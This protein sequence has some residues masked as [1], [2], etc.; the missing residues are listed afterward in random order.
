LAG[1]AD[2][3]SVELTAEKGQRHCRYAYAV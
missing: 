2:F 3:D 1:F